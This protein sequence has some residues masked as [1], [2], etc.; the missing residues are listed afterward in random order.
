M[1]RNE[2]FGKFYRPSLKVCGKNRNAACSPPANKWR[3]FLALYLFWA[4]C[5]FT[6]SNLPRNTSAPRRKR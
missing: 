4:F 2:E 5:Y 3:F 1:P 6:I